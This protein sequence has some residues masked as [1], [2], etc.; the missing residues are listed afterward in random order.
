MKGEPK[1][2]NTRQDVENWRTLA[3]ED[4]YKATIQRFY[5]ARLTWETTSTLTE[6]QSGI[7]DDTHR[8]LENVD[9][10]TQEL[11]RYQQELQANPDAYIFT[12]LGYTDSECRTILELE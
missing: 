1:W 10:E 6:G 9:M 3:G 7:T 2:F 8:V 11:V 4:A 12:R 5:D